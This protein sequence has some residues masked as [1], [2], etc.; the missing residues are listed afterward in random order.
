[1]SVAAV[2]L[3]L[4]FC[5]VAGWSYA[6]ARGDEALAYAAARDRALADGRAR[7]AHLTG[8]DTKDPA[9]SR[10]RWLAASTGPLHE[11]LRRSG[12]DGGTESPDRTGKS[13]GK[14]TAGSKKERQD[15][16]GGTARATVTDAA[17]TALDVRAGSA[18]MIATVRIEGGFGGAERKRLQAA[19]AR[20]PQ[21]WKVEA[22]TA[23]PVGGA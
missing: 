17:L 12:T 23:V 19:L 8:H 13:A 21:G 10:Q 2:V 6:R 9:R 14:E 3:A 5:A 1:M 22:L 16:P 18:E 7:I 11:E 20:T 4:L 15:A